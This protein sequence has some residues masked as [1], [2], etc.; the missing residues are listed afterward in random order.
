MCCFPQKHRKV[1]EACKTKVT[2]VLSG[3]PKKGTKSELAIPTLPARGPKRGQN[4]YITL[5]F[6]GILNKGTKSKLATSPLPS[7]MAQKRTEWLHDPCF[8]GGLQ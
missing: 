5:A 3:V 4:G 8:L 1:N 7:W 6:S 2:P